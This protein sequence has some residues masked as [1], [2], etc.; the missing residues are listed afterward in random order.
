MKRLVNI[1][2]NASP[3]NKKKVRYLVVG[4]WNTVFPYIVFGLLYYLS[5]ARLHYL[6]ILLISQVLGLTN[7]YIGYKFF[8][9]K[10]KGNYVREYLRFYAV[11]GT[12]FIVNIVLISL[13]VEVLGI[14]PV[15][16]QGIIGVI[17]VIMAYIGHDR[18]SFS[19]K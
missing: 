2:T 17:V 1:V 9:F 11:Y 13:F 7:A 12:T 8:V 19:A 5:N 18:F 16:S 6:I 14:N 3:E 4:L 15:I 10:T